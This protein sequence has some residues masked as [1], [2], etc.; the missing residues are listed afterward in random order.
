MCLKWLIKSIRFASVL[1]LARQ[2]GSR[3]LNVDLHLNLFHSSKDFNTL[4][5]LGLLLFNYTG[6]CVYALLS[7][8]APL[9]S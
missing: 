6:F 9:I 8:K 2:C 3:L 1:K 7:E 4:I 5:I